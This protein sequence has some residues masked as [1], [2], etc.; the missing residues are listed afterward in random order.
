MNYD[1][2]L[3]GVGG[4]GIL[5]IGEILAETAQACNIPV[6]FFPSK[7]MA[8]RGGFVK[9]QLRLGCEHAGPNIPER[10]ADMV[11]AM[12][13]SE[14]LKAVRYIKKG[15]D[16]VLYADV[17]APTAVLLGK[18]PY[19]NFDQVHDQVIR[20][21]AHLIWLTPDQLPH[22]HGEPVAANIY[23]LGLALGRTALGQLLLPQD[24]SRVIAFRW[25]RG[26]EAN[27]YAFQSGLE[28]AAPIQDQLEA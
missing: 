3:V 26:L 21:G 7:G 15:G 16:F 6:N 13:L 17:W 14:S 18:A 12:E 24:V 19:P 1:I 11:I 4:Q 10:G 20:S 23:V 27:L 9:A 22:F 25:R 28:S 8:Q 5:T 2:F